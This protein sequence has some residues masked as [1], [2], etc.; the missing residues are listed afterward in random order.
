MEYLAKFAR[1]FVSL[2]GLHFCFLVQSYRDIAL[3]IHTYIPEHDMSSYSHLAKKTAPTVKILSFVLN[4]SLKSIYRKL[5]FRQKCREPWTIVVSEPIA[6]E[7]FHKQFKVINDHLPGF[8]R[9][10]EIVRNKLGK[11]VSYRIKFAHISTFKFHVGQIIGEDKIN[12]VKKNK[13]TKEK[14]KIVCAYE[15]S[16]KIDYNIS[17]GILMINLKYNLFNRYGQLCSF[18]LFVNI[19]MRLCNSVDECPHDFTKSNCGMP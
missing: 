18:Q 16:T 6:R 12:L 15:T 9:T 1:I 7:F 11:A 17:K 4:Q 3:Y 10:V 5:S 13:T 8:G 2:N 14:V 19:K